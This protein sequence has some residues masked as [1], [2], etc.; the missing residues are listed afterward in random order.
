MCSTAHIHSKMSLGIAD[1]KKVY[2]TTFEARNKWKNI[3]LELEV[4]SDTT[5]SIGEKYR[6][7]PEDCYREG[8]KEWLKNGER[9]WRDL[10]EAFSSPTVGHGDLASVIEKEHIQHADSASTVTSGIQAGM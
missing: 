6:D 4:S 3:L 9:N 10:V 2:K 7:S 5:D 1:L 8:L